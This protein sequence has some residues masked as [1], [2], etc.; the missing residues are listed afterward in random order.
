MRNTGNMSTPGTSRAT[1]TTS[2]PRP[3]AAPEE[4]LLPQN[5]EAEAGVLGS[6]LIDPQ[7][8]PMVSGFLAP[9]DFYR[10][11]HRDIYEAFL[12]LW[13]LGEPAD[14]ITL[15][16]ELARTGK[17]DHVGGTP[18]VSS[19]ANQVPTSANIEHY[20]HIVERTAI[21]RRLIHTAGQIAAVA[22]TE[23]DALTALD[24][25]R[26]LLNE[27]SARHARRGGLW[28]GE[29]INLY[30]AE[31]LEVLERGEVQGVLSGDPRV[32]AH[33]L[34]FK[35]GE[36]VYMAGRP[37]SGK[38]TVAAQ[39]AYNIA[40]ACSTRG[41]PGMVEWI[42]LEMDAT[43]IVGRLLS[44][45]GSIPNGVMRANF[46]RPDGQ[47][48]QSTYEYMT[49]LAQAERDRMGRRIHYTDH[50]IKMSQV[51]DLLIRQVG[52]HGCVCAVVDYL[53]LVEPENARA[54]NYQRISD[55]SRQLKQVAR[56]L[57]IPIICLLQL[58]RETEKR[59]N[60]RPMVSDLRDSGQL[61]QDADWIFGI[62]RHA[63]YFPRRAE[64][65]RAQ[66]GSLGKLLE[67]SVLKA[68]AG[69]AGVTIPVQF[70]GEYT[71]T[72]PWPEGVEWEAY[73][74]EVLT[75]DDDTEVA[76]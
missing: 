74:R 18:Y 27:V 66:G 11:A 30:L 72:S 1:R 76:L 46:R 2:T 57:R 34:G 33:C 52:E 10:E 51:R 29:A 68:R 50:P 9:E 36:L 73:A 58:N 62:Y 69:K 4:I 14:L 13:E 39:W 42:T 21:L 41:G 38:S 55:M 31:T 16:D 44:S 70:E 71:R 59:L 32:D 56:E 48:A 54:D 26:T 19:L 28:H 23:P 75:A 15:T 43:Q 8:L 24:T 6:L 22:Y 64:A 65:D 7:A 67:L 61:E 25:A 12:A 40:E 45:L 20:G 49:R 17:L 60:K 53:G 63:S 47:I 3:E 37:G 5:I 35:P